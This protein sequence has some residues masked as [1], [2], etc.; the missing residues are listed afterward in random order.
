MVAHQP[1]LRLARLHCRQHAAHSHGSIP[2]PTTTCPGRRTPTYLRADTLL[3]LWVRSKECAL[4]LDDLA[5]QAGSAS[6]STS[7]VARP[8]SRWWAIGLFW[9]AFGFTVAGATLFGLV[10]SLFDYFNSRCL[11]S[12]SYSEMCGGLA[13]L[14]I[15]PVLMMASW[16]AVVIRHREWKPAQHAVFQAGMPVNSA[17]RAE[18]MGLRRCHSIIRKTSQQALSPP[19]EPLRS[20]S[21]ANAAAG[22]KRRRC[23]SGVRWRL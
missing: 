6:H 21:K 10:I 18:L 17:C 2:A 4:G 7:G 11:M 5:I 8:L 19:K 12:R 16:V 3:R 20:K 23:S 1:L 13:C 15:G 9:P 14:A 22:V